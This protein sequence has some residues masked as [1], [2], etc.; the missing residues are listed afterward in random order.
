M[1]APGVGQMSRAM[2]HATVGVAIAAVLMGGMLSPASG[3]PTGSAFAKLLPQGILDVAAV[4]GQMI[5]GQPVPTMAPLNPD[6][7]AYQR[8][9]TMPDVSTAI[10]DGFRAGVIPHP[11][12]MSHISPRREA[13]MLVGY[14]ASYDLRTASP[15]PK[16][17]GV[18]NQGPAGSCWAHATYASLESCL[19]PG[20]LWDFSENHLKNTRGFDHAHDAGGNHIM[21]TAYLARWSG[22]VA[23]ADD[24]YNPFSGFSPE[25]LEPRKHVQEVM[26][27]ANDSDEIKWAITTHGAVH[28]SYFHDGSYYNSEHSAY[29]YPVEGTGTNHA[30]ATVGWDDDFPADRFSTIPPG[31]GAWI[32]KNSWGEGWGDGGYGYISYYDTRFVP[33]ALFRNAE[34]T[35]NYERNYQY[36]P[37]GRVGYLARIIHEASR[38]RVF[39]LG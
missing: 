38:D 35:T 26:W 22:P 2:R 17:T 21:S 29:Y 28:T 8:A 19:L 7:V 14:P 11:V 39:V 13:R 37:L 16:L 3:A 5:G 4:W 31:D 10:G 32:I 27:L 25:G 36:D 34:P 24:P 12:D 6:F 20:E 18:R 1:T 30:V 33:R 15:G 9:R 23:E